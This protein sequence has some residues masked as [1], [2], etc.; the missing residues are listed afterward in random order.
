MPD[1][2]VVMESR[3]KQRIAIALKCKP[4]EVPENQAELKAA[5]DNRRTELKAQKA[6]K[7]G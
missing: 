3:M 7:H 4:S 5:L 6:V 2:E 1:R